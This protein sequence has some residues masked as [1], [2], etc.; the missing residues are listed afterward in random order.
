MSEC[1]ELKSGDFKEYLKCYK[2][3][4]Q[5]VSL[6]LNLSSSISVSSVLK[7]A[8]FDALVQLDLLTIKISEIELLSA[9]SSMNQ[10]RSMSFTIPKELSQSNL[11]SRREVFGSIEK[12]A[13][14]VDVLTIRSLNFLNDLLECLKGVRR[15]ELLSFAKSSPVKFKVDLTKYENKFEQL[16]QLFFDCVDNIVHAEPLFLLSWIHGGNV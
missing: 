13:I 4:E 15:L 16:D 2:Q 11:H 3:L 10:L 1:Y 8:K 14:D 9:V 7:A 6:N 12:M 5:I